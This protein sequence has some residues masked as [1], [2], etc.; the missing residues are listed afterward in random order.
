MGWISIK[1]K[2]PEEKGIYQVLRNFSDF[3]PLIFRPYSK[4]LLQIPIP[5]DD[6]KFLYSI[7][8]LI[9]KSISNISFK[10]FPNTLK[11][12]KEKQQQFKGLYECAKAKEEDAEKKKA[13]KAQWPFYRIR[14]PHQSDARVFEQLRRKLGTITAT[15]RGDY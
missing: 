4:N 5:G 6:S 14:L 7:M 12:L 13:R 15:R 3:P 2:L 9:E 11:K 10:K 1:D 8:Q